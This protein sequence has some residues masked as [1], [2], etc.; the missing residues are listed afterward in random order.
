MRRKPVGRTRR[1]RDQASPDVGGVTAYQEVCA[2][3]SGQIARC[4][5]RGVEQA[6]LLESIGSETFSL[7]GELDRH[8]P[9]TVLLQKASAL[10]GLVLHG[11]GVLAELQS[12][13]GSL[14]VFAAIRQAETQSTPEDQR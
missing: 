4:A 8:A 5:T 14:A 13:A 1:V 10:R 3:V 9:P 6:T 11:L 12:L 7:V 2:I